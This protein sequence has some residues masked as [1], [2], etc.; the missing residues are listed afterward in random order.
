MVTLSP[1][2]Q[3]VPTAA[4]LQV[5]SVGEVLESS[6]DAALSVPPEA[7]SLPTTWALGPPLSPPSPNGTAE[8]HCPLRHLQFLPGLAFPLFGEQ[9]Q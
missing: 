2:A 1:P 4:T 8:P 9:N 6:G 7:T 3:W 5:G